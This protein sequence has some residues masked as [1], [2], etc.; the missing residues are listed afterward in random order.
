MVQLSDLV[1][2]KQLVVAELRGLSRGKPR[3]SQHDVVDH[4]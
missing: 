4:E 2:E 1:E 3:P